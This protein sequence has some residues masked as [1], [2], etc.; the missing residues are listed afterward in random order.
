MKVIN[1]LAAGLSIVTNPL[2]TDLTHGDHII[3]EDPPVVINSDVIINFYTN[4]YYGSFSN[5]SN[6][7]VKFYF[8]EKTS[9]HYFYIKYYNQRTNALLVNES[10]KLSDYLESDLSLEYTIKCKG[11]LNND[12]LKI[13]FS[14]ENASGGEKKEKTIRIYPTN[15]ETIYSYQYVN[16]PYTVD[17]RIFKITRTEIKYRESVRFENTIDYLTN[18]TDNSIDI[19]EVTFTYDEGFDLYNKGANKYLKILDLDNI[20]PYINKS[21]DGYIY[22]PLE[23]VQNNKDIS[24]KFKNHF[25]YNP[26]TLDISLTSRSGFIETEKFYIP[27]GKLKLLENATFAVEM[28]QFGRSKF[29]VIIP[30]NFVKDRNYLG[31]C[32]DSSHCIIGGIRA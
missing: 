6:T 31:L 13:V 15:N 4:S 19:S 25:Y 22:I 30:L 17:E 26:S 18:D 21:G 24:L 28:R 12:G 32:S 3:I 2:R 23:C 8:T 9:R 7:M 5:E 20:F 11:K 10:Y 16:S 27:I 1:L 14:T 29:N